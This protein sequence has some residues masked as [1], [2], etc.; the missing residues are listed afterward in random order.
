MKKNISIIYFFFVLCSSFLQAQSTNVIFNEDFNKSLTRIGSQYVPQGGRDSSL[1][2]FNH[3]SSFYYLA[4]KYFQT[5]PNSEGVTRTTANENVYNIDNGYYAVIAPK[6]I[7]DFSTDA[8]D[9]LGYKGNWWRKVTNNTDSS[10]NG[11]VL[12]VNGGQ[13]LNQ[14]YRRSVILEKGKTY[15]YSAWF[16]MSGNNNVAVQFE[17]QTLGTENVIGNSGRMDIG[18]ES[19]KWVYKSWTFKLDDS[20]DCTN[21]AMALR[22]ASASN[23][24]NDFYVDDIVL[25]EVVDPNAPVITCSG[26]PAID[27]FIKANDDQLTVTDTQNKFDIIAN[28]SYEKIVGDVR[29]NG[30]NKNSTISIQDTWPEGVILNPDTGEVTISSDYFPQTDPL[31]Y[32]ICNLLGECSEANITITVPYCYQ[33]PTLGTPKGT[34]TVGISTNTFVDKAWPNNIPNGYISLDSPS[35]PMVITRTIATKIANPIEGMIIYDTVD[36]CVKLYNGSTWN[37]IKK[38]CNN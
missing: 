12:V 26:A 6:N 2:A 29:L 10:D 35:K 16:F 13:I 7:Y 23:T 28:D 36:K 34:T 33:N 8:P 9:G 20:S 3:G 4:D 27:D 1:G 24:G 22:N 38:A 14:Y 19:N 5:S 37:C 18:N 31:K 32:Q 17:A 21:L 11:A 30:S 25:E 15:R